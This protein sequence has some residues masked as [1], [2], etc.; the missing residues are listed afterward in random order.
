MPDTRSAGVPSVA[1]WVAI[2]IVGLGT[3]IAPLDT[4]VNV[5]FPAIT[6][7]FQIPVRDIQWII[8]MFGL[9][10]SSLT[11]VFGKLGDRYGHHRVFMIGLFI[12]AVAL[13]LCAIAPSY[14]SL[15]VSRVFQGIGAGLVM[16]CG[17]A[18]VTFILPPSQRRKALAFYTMLMGLGMCLGP[19]AGGFLVQLAGWP[20]VYWARVPI[21]LL[22]LALVWRLSD[23]ESNAELVKARSRAQRLPFDWLGACALVTALSALIFV[24]AQLRSP[25]FGRGSIVLLTVLCAVSFLVLLKN[26]RAAN[27]ILDL[28]HFADARFRNL[29]IAALFIQITTFSLFLLM[30][31]RLADWPG[32]GMIE[33]GI[34]LA[35]FP[36]GTVAAGFF[37]SRMSVRI[38]SIQ[39]VP[40]GMLVAGLGLM[41]SGFFSAHAW[42]FAVATALFTTGVGLGLFQVGHLDATLSAMH[43]GDRGVAGSLVSVERVLGFAISANGV[44][45]LHDWL[46]DSTGVAES[47]SVAADYG[48]TFVLIGSALVVA[49]VVFGANLL[50]D[51]QRK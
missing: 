36:A 19:L 30:P 49:A 27:P 10:Q 20:A 14:P 33:A 6:S 7:A 28:R 35:L 45:W 9:A 47:A 3:L 11:L 38:K 23:L 51:R 37:G 48:E 8:T 12:S 32:I 2:V 40:V 24:I 50:A 46:R 21:A 1:P 22:A 15:I 13:A 26:Q 5:A 39:L 4:A 34:L 31:Y 17:P 18:L 29:Q 25:A 43:V 41:G 16:A 44:M 42:L